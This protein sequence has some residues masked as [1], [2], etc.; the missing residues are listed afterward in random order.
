MG[1]RAKSEWVAQIVRTWAQNI[2]GTPKAKKAGPMHALQHNSGIVEVYTCSMETALYT[3]NVQLGCK[4]LLFKCSMT[5]T[6]M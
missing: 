6:H 1:G 2:T 4:N 5:F 3:G